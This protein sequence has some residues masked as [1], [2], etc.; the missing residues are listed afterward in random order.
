MNAPAEIPARKRFSDLTR[1]ELVQ[2][3][4]D[5]G[6]PAYRAEQIRKWM[7]AKRANSFDEMNDLPKSLRTALTEHF[8]LFTAKLVRHLV[9]KDRTEKL[10]LELGDGEVVECVLMR[11]DDRRTICI[12]TQVGCAMGCIFCAS[13]MEGLK[14]NLSTGEILEQ[15][16]RLD[17]L[18]P[19]E[20]R[21][22]NMV[23]MGIGEPLA[24]LGALVPTL[25]VMTDKQGLGLGARRITVSTVGLPEKIREFARLG[26]QYHLAISLHAPNDELRN[27]LVPVNHRIGVNAIMAAADD[28]FSVTG[29]RV[30][31]EYVLLSQL[32]DGPEQAREL[33]DLLKGRR[34]HVNLIPMNPVKE[35]DLDEPVQ[36]RTMEFRRILEEFGVAVTIRKRKGADID[37]ACGQLR[38]EH[39]HDRPVVSLDVSSPE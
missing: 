35:L 4:G 21:I 6:E 13:G 18:L 33:A 26:H 10:L 16:L 25:A 39:E 12:S 17:R 9:A 29:R 30:T 15:V 36:P 1:D 31:Y 22:T 14:R 27:R 32:N 23:V 11:E 19:S 20:E 8:D 24:N 38:L 5:R 2:W 34:A 7:F 3:C 28:Y 37:A